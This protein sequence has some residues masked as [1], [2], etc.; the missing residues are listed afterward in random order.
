M[1]ESPFPFGYTDFLSWY[2]DITARRLRPALITLTRLLGEMF[3]QELAEFERQRIRVSTG[4]VKQPY[5]LWSKMLQEKNRNAISSLDSILTAIDDLIGLRVVCNNLSDIARVQEIL[6]SLP[7]ADDA[8]YLPLAIEAE[9]ERRYYQEPKLTGYRAYHINVVTIVPGADGMHRLRGELQ[10]RTLLQEG[11]GELTHEDT[12]KPGA[13]LPPLAVTLARRMADL[14]ATVD[15]MAEDI[16]K[17]LDRAVQ[18]AVVDEGP[19]TP[20]VDVDSADVVPALLRNATIVEQP[21]QEGTIS[22]RDLIA[23]VRS[24][25]Q[26]LSKPA[27]LA[28]IAHR[29]Q[30]TF[31]PEVTNG[32]GGYSSFKLLL[33][34]AVPDV[35]VIDAGPGY[36]VPPGGT[37]E[38]PPLDGSAFVEETDGVPDLVLRLRKLDK[39]VPAI[40]GSHIEG[41]TV[42]LAYCLS[43]ETWARLE[44]ISASGHTSAGLREVNSL[45]RAAR[46]WAADRGVTVARQ[47]LDYLLKALLW[48]GNLR[49][50]LGLDEAIDVISHW[51]CVRAASYGVVDDPYV[52]RQSIRRWLEGEGLDDSLDET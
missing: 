24:I 30:S 1:P 9:S 19:L 2:E 21:Q 6:G 37:L 50:K 40:S 43:E 47:H 29:L 34:A 46:D 49:P 20:T 18:E 41:L 17:E 42:A 35:E 5:R 10:V 16:R 22:R 4:R 15:D 44:L 32:W 45:S 26:A 23:E 39:S 7:N 25:V 38:K 13:T 31:G 52:N 3:D 51:F 36:V 11:W 12:Y 8:G 48:S 28:S 33:K 14:L 27:S